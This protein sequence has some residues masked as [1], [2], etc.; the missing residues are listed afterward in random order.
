MNLSKDIRFFLAALFVSIAFLCFVPAVQ[1]TTAPI[2]NPAGAVVSGHFVPV[3]MTADA[4]AQIY[5][6][7]DG[8]TPTSGSTLYTS[9]F[10]VLSS[11]VVKAIAILSGVSSSVTVSYICVDYD[12]N[13]VIN[14]GP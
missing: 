7:L 1:A 8:S 5:Y 14:T 2:I 12:A 10:A 9:S 11:T 13:A 3:G 4:G 6:T